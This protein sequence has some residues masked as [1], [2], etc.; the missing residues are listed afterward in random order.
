M[1]LQSFNLRIKR[2]CYVILGTFLTHFP[3]IFPGQFTHR[4]FQSRTFPPENLPLGKSPL[5]IF[6]RTFLLWTI[7]KTFLRGQFQRTFRRNDITLE[8]FR[9]AEVQDL[10]TTTIHG[11]QY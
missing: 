11:V 6:Q 9:V 7:H 8:L 10:L 3:E 5:R 2:I 1:Q 4:H